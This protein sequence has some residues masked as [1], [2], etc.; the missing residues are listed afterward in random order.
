MKGSF[1]PKNIEKYRGNLS[2]IVYRSQYE[3]T[4]MMWCDHN[5]SV[6]EWS[7]EEVIITYRSILDEL[8][9]KRTNATKRKW[10]RYFPDF[11]VK[12]KTKE[13]QIIR[14]LI[15]VKPFHET[16]EPIVEGT[17]KSKKTILTQRRTWI[18]NNAKWTAARDF[19]KK[20]DM[21]FKLVTEKELY[22]RK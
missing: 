15:E 17:R 20:R 1:N 3:L 14:Y 21:I 6:V 22:G 9:E 10:H 11:Y 12:V 8:E 16:R 13:G 19:C 7:S 5:E 18:V 4:F 2:N